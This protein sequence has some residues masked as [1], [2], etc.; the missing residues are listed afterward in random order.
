MHQQLPADHRMSFCVPIITYGKGN[1]EVCIVR[2]EK[3]SLEEQ[4]ILHRLSFYIGVP[5]FVG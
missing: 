3:E 5:N 2:K 1:N 4:Y